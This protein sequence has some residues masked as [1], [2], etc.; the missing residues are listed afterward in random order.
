MK[1]AFTGNTRYF[2]KTREAVRGI[3]RDIS[4]CTSIMMVNRPSQYWF[5]PYNGRSTLPLEIKEGS[6]G[7]RKRYLQMRSENAQQSQPPSIV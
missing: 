1:E 6:A 2:N 4:K 5:W 3:L 7:K